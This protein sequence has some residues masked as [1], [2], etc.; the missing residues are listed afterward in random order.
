MNYMQLQKARADYVEAIVSRMS[1]ADC[2]D[3]VYE[4]MHEFARNMSE[5]ELIDAAMQSAP[6]ILKGVAL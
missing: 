5:A 6:E 2:R 3:F 4:E 1:D